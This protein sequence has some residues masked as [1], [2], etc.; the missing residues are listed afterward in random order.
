MLRPYRG[1]LPRVHP[2]AYIDDS[3]QVIGDVEIGEESSVWMAVVIRGDV[4]RIRIGRRTNVQDGTIVHVMK[5]T[6]PTTIGHDVTI[7]HA[8][9][10]HGCTIEDQCLIGM[11][12]I[13]LNGVRI[14]T[15]SIVAAGTLLPEGAEIPPRSLVMGAPGKVRRTLTD[16]DVAEIQMYADRYVS[17]RLDYMAGVAVRTPGE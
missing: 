11:G 17:Y 4:H 5:D 1:I 14:G 8:A 13:L 12:A 16:S 2:T 15:G 9:V 3:A 7:G 6:H 10:V